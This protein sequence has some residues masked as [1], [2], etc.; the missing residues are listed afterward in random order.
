[1]LTVPKRVNIVGLRLLTSERTV[2]KVAPWLI[3]GYSDY[4]RVSTIPSQEWLTIPKVFTLTMWLILH[5]WFPSGCL[6][7]W[8]VLDRG[9]LHD[10]PPIKTLGNKNLKLLLNFPDRHFTHVTV[11]HNPLL[12]EWSASVWPHWGGLLG[13]GIWLPSDCVPCTFTLCWLCFVS[14]RVIN[15]SHNY[16]HLLSHVS[17][18]SEASNLWVVLGTHDAL[19]YTYGHLLY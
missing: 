16:D 8:W 1:M 5:T 6:K 4:E 11:S 10:Q 12:G 19:M 2:C 15:H 13:A 9:Y 7:L 18:P 14:S 17:P 3:G